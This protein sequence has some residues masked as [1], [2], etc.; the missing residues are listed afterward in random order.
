VY[1]QSP[2][3]TMF[4]MVGLPAAGKTTAASSDRP[5]P[6]PRLIARRA[7]LESG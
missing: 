2:A 4:L 7:S 3:T 1:A 6:G 5:S